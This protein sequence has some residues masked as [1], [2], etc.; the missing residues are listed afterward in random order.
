ME[1]ERGGGESERERGTETTE[2]Q[3]QDDSHAGKS[4]CRKEKDK[5][6]ERV[7]EEG[8][9]KQGGNDGMDDER[10]NRKEG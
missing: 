2:T 3:R 9:R 7:Q 6:E 10:K 8:A 5:V 1:S 4:A